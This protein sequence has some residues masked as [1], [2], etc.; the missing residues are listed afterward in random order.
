MDPRASIRAHRIAGVGCLV[1]LV[2][3]TLGA[4]GLTAFVANLATRSIV[5]DPVLLV[6]GGLLTAVPVLIAAR[7]AFLGVWVSSQGVTCRTWLT[8]RH[9]A[10]AD[11]DECESEPYQGFLTKGAVSRIL[12]ELVI[13]SKEP[14]VVFVG[15]SVATRKSSGRQCAAINAAALEFASRIS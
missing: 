7:A 10:W 13:Y 6:F 12:R 3:T 2:W 15:G 14:R 8:R 5:H 4:V 9:I 11:F 1:R